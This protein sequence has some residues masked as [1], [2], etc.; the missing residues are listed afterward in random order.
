MLNFIS[1]LFVIIS[2]SV[3]AKGPVEIIDPMVR[4]TPP[5]AAVTAIFLKIKNT[6]DQDM[7]LVKVAGEAPLT[8]ELHNMEMKDARM[9]MRRVDSIDIKAH[10]EVTLTSGG[11]HIMVFN[12]KKSLVEGAILPI[13][14]HFKDNS[15]VPVQVI[16]K[17]M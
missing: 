7:K 6:S 14:L 12:L 2:T 10:A 13:K 4:L 5:G 1:L 17:K 15:E 8:F 3:M 9:V 16:V 11:L